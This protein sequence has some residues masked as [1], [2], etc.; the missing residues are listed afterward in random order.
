M[1]TVT[2]KKKSLVCSIHIDKQTQIEIEIDKNCISF[3]DRHRK[4][5][6]IISARSIYKLCKY[7]SKLE[8]SFK[9]FFF[10]MSIVFWFNED[11]TYTKNWKWKIATWGNGSSHPSWNYKK[12]ARLRFEK[13]CKTVHHLS[14]NG[15]IFLC[16]DIFNVG[17]SLKTSK[18]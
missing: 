5:V 14:L 16:A 8:N 6:S 17:S 18:F 4:L 12:S 3:I 2:T 11:S 7:L 10:S 15:Y 13:N 9:S 1:L